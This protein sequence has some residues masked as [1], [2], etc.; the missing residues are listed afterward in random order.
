M[1]YTTPQKI[2]LQE[3][4]AKVQKLPQLPEAALRLTKVME[5]PDAHAEDM[6]AIIR[7]DP[8]MTTQ[9]LRLC[10]SAAYALNRRIS[11]V[12]DAVAILGLNTLK[13]MV[14]V[15]ISKFA[16]DRPVEGYG[17][18]RGALWRNALTCAVYARHL[19]PRHAQG[20]DPELAFTGALLRDIG[21]IVLGE[22]V[23]RSYQDI[24]R[25][26]MQ[27]RID[28]IEAE[29]E[30]LG[31][32]HC[33]V[34]KLIAEKWGL[35]DTLV[36][37]IQYKNKP[38]LLAKQPPAIGS[39]VDVYKLVSLVHLA[40]CF[41]RMTGCGLGS[42]GLMSGFDETALTSLGIQLSAPFI[43]RTL[44]QLVTQDHLVEEMIQSLKGGA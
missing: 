29:Q 42:D 27:K 35:P 28:F 32:N 4:I 43:E 11:T 38:S 5:D 16:L 24:E 19:A 23:G 25:L 18:D 1:A 34:G 26:A 3:L 15:I 8:D 10:N 22:Y 6:A 40:D 12:K 44:D 20:V 13:S 14:Y 21:K 31:F 9:V 36:K 30:V 37:V 41:T 7:V 2:S 33:M 17:L 39:K